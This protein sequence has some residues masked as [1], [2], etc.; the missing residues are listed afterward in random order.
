VENHR[1]ELREETSKKTTNQT[2]CCDAQDIVVRAG[3]H[4]LSIGETVWLTG[5]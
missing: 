5:A 1:P 3:K 2:I 4:L